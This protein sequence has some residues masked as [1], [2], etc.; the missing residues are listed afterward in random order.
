MLFF[1]LPRYKDSL[2]EGHSTWYS[3]HP[4]GSE[5]IESNNSPLLTVSRSG[6]TRE[7]KK[8]RLAT[9]NSFYYVETMD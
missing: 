6:G 7:E 5:E 2:R 4:F 9:I 1:R 8:R 3:Q